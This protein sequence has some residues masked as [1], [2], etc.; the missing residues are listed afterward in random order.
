MTIEEIIR[1]IV[2]EEMKNI[3]SDLNSN[4]INKCSTF[5]KASD[6]AEILNCSQRM[7]YEIM[8]YK[9]FPLVKIGRMKR[10]GRNDFFQWLEMSK[11]SNRR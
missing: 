11:N 6:I 2:Q 7:A 1:N 9:D 5:L 8:A 10:V 3:L 4:P